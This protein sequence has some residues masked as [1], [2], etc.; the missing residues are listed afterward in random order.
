[1]DEKPAKLKTLTSVATVIEAM[2]SRQISASHSSPHS[3][4]RMGLRGVVLVTKAL[5]TDGAPKA[6]REPLSFHRRM[7]SDYPRARARGRGV[8][9][10]FLAFDFACLL[11]TGPDE[12][13]AGT[14]GSPL[15]DARALSDSAQ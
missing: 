12:F 9:D 2:T 4:A 15:A 14:A 1:M 5:P 8:R 11:C 6:A 13:S 7:R 10:F 3:S